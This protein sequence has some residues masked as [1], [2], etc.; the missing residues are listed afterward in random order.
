MARY[1]T[2][3]A[4]GMA[5]KSAARKSPLDTSMAIRGF[6]YDRFLCRRVQRRRA[7]LHSQRRARNARQNDKCPFHYRRR[8]FVSKNRYQ[9]S[10]R[11]TEAHSRRSNCGDYMEFRFKSI[12][13]IAEAQ[14]YREGFRITFEAVLGVRKVD[15]VSVDLVTDRVACENPD[16]IASESRLDI[17]GLA[18]FDYLV[19]PVE[20]MIVD[21]ICATM[22]GYADGSPSSRVK[23][24]VRSR[25]RFS[26]RKRSNQPFSPKSLS[27][28]SP[29]Y[30]NSA[31][32]QGSRCPHFG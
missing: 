16:V 24:L 11:A 8:S 27:K 15:D 20:Y 13:P 6:Y 32:T 3:E 9:R 25:Y 23:D 5:V 28:S 30:A 19:Y 17:E 14:E 26:A 7:G 21:K 18:T 12:A 31:N 29:S 1:R 22:G 10:G 2:A 4:L